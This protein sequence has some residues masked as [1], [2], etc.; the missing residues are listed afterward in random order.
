MG[1]VANVRTGDVKVDRAVNALG[2]RLNGLVDS[3]FAQAVP[4]E[5]SLVEGLN[6]IGHRLGQTVP[7]FT[8][9]A[10][11]TTGI[12]IGSAQTENPRPDQQVWVRMA[13]VSSTK[14]LLFLLPVIG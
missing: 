12:T 2:D 8:H 9:A 7:Y 14:A 1:P 4:L 5:V 11:P 3:S 6:K 13:G 10:L